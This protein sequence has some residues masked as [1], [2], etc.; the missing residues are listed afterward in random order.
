MEKSQI[1]VRGKYLATAFLLIL[2]QRLKNNYAKKHRNYPR[3]LTDMYGLMVTFEPTRETP[4]AGG[5]AMKA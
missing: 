4:V 1:S 3:T 5:D 2:D